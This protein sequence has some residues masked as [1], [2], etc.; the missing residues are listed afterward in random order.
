M[1][2][3]KVVLVYVNV[4]DVLMCGVVIHSMADSPAHN[5]TEDNPQ[6]IYIL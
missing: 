3:P 6:D 1:V 2:L 4:P 5:P